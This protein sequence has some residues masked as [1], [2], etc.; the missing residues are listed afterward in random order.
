MANERVAPKDAN[1]QAGKKTDK[2][3]LR[4]DAVRDASFSRRGQ[5][6]DEG[7]DVLVNAVAPCQPGAALR[8]FCK[9]SRLQGTS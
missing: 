9:P 5:F 2:R 4:L 7:G 1:R 6:R 8:Q 3:Q